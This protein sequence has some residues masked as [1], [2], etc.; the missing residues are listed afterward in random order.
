MGAVVNGTLACG[1]APGV[2]EAEATV[3]A[4]GCTATS[5][6]EAFVQVESTADNTTDDHK[7]LAAL[8]RFI[9][10]PQTDQVVVTAK[11][12]GGFYAQGDFNIEVVWN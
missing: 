9:C 6:A 1:A 5:R 4:V 10:E 3:A 12:D 11:I 8:V 2:N 7:T